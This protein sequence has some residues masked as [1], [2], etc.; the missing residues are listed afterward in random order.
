LVKLFKDHDFLKEESFGDS[1]EDNG[2][3]ANDDEDESDVDGEF[4]E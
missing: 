2:M 1:G 3:T 4:V